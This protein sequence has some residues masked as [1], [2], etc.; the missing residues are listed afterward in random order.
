MENADFGMN[1]CIIH[2]VEEINYKQVQYSI[3]FASM[4]TVDP[5]QG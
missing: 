2:S 3:V 1:Q 4:R 5:V